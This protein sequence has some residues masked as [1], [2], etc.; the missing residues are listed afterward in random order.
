MG[1]AAENSQ[2]SSSPLKRRASDLEDPSEIATTKPDVE[3]TNV[4][5]VEPSNGVEASENASAVRTSTQA[6]AADETPLKSEPKSPNTEAK[7]KSETEVPPIDAQIK[8]V[9]AIAEASRESALQDGDQAYLVS[10]RWLK[11]VMERGTESRQ[12]SKIQPEGE[13]GPVDN[14]DLIQQIIKDAD[15]NDFVQLKPGAF[16]SLE[17]FPKDAWDLIVECTS[18]KYVDFLEKIKEKASIEKTKKVRIWRVPRLLPAANPSTSAPD[19][20]T[21]PSSRP[22]SPT[23]ANSLPN[24]QPQ[25]SW[26]HLLLD[27]TTFLKLPNGNGRELVEQRDCVRSVEELTKYFLSGTAKKELNYDNPLGNHGNVALAYQ[28]LLEE[29]YKEPVPAS[30]APRQFKTTIGKYAP[31]FSGYGQQDSQEFL[32]FLLDGLQEDLSRVKKKPYIEKPDSTD[33]MINNPDLIREMAAKVWEIT[34]LRDDSVIA[35][36]FTGMYKSTLVCPECSKVS[37][38]FDPF[39]NLTLQLPIENSWQHNAFYFPLNDP[40]VTISID[41]DKQGTIFAMKQFISKRVGVPPERLFA[42]EEFK[43]KFYKIFKDKQVASEEISSN[44]VL[45]VYEIEDKPTN[46]PPRRVKR[47][48]SHMNFGNN[49]SEDDDVPSWD[50]PMAEKMLVPVFHRRPNPERLNRFKKAWV[51]TPAPHFIVLNPKEARDLESIKRKILEKVATFSSDADSSGDGKVVASSIDGEDELVDVAMKDA[52]ATSVK[53]TNGTDNSTSSEADKQFTPLRAFNKRRPKLLDPSSHLNPRLQNMF[54]LGHF[55]ADKEMIPSGWNCVDDDKSYSPLSDRLPKV[56]SASDNGS[57]EF[58]LDSPRGN[59]ESSIED[60]SFRSDVQSNQ[61]RMNEESSDE[62][63]LARPQPT[64][65]LPVRSVGGVRTNQQDIKSPDVDSDLEEAPTKD[66]GPLVRLGEGIVVDWHPDAWEALFDG[67]PGDTMRGCDT[68]SSIPTL[69][70]PELEAKKAARQTRRKNGITLEDCLNEFGKEEILSEMDTWYCPRCKEH[71]RASKKFELWRTPDILIMHLKRFSSSAMRRDKLDVM[72]NFPVEGLDLTSRVIET[73]DGK[74]EIYDLIAVDDHWGGLGGGHYTAFA[75]SYV[76]GDWYEY[77]GS[78]PPNYNMS[79]WNF[80][81]LAN[82]RGQVSGTGSDEMDDGASDKVN[83][84]SSASDASR[85]DRLRD[86]DDSVPMEDGVP[87]EDQCPVPD[88]S[89]EQQATIIDMHHTLAEHRL[90]GEKGLGPFHVESG[91][92]DDDEEPAAEIHVDDEP[93]K[94]E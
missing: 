53:A 89:D 29:M 34:K 25:D 39:N 46:W 73:Q 44:D 64:R 62:D 78:A 4:S 79:Q 93:W 19:S 58:E 31:S 13:I 60:N 15:G 12:N 61:T 85:E 33:E 48:K 67:T 1:G 77:N 32:G 90:I 9:T 63:E 11:R 20:A 41:M 8:T 24:R 40:P 49:D 66:Q 47:V 2:R 65:A 88:A 30:T 43:S 57:E 51:L 74:Q 27:V 82:G 42:A 22:G 70:D 54:S 14:S 16:E 18:N 69:P 81:G 50:D 91:L 92:D 56:K 52:S 75:K 87:F 17:L 68:T 37:I 38:T 59:S 83:M 80:N 21:P 5:D 84:N 35:D 6:K 94:A 86:F 10:K 45:V 3:M 23:S 28:R 26:N 55:A 76:D 7:L 71:R 72:V 36:L